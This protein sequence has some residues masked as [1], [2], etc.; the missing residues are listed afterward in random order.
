MNHTDPFKLTIFFSALA[1]ATLFS[2]TPQVAEARSALLAWTPSPPVNSVTGEPITETIYYRV[3][4]GTSS[5][6]YTVR[7]NVDLRELKNGEIFHERIVPFADDV[8]VYFVVTAYITKTQPTPVEMESKYSNEVVQAGKIKLLP[9]DDPEIIGGINDNPV[10]N[11]LDRP[12]QPVVEF[13]VAGVPGQTK[14]ARDASGHPIVP[15]NIRSYLEGQFPELL[16][17]GLVMVF[18]LDDDGGFS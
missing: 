16:T 9:P 10:A 2:T 4:M 5:G 11:N 8:K 13:I 17:G 12:K 7:E 6:Q 3:Y 1:L 15:A 18:E 14:F